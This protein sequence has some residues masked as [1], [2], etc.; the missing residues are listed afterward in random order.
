M[1]TVGKKKFDYTPSG[2]KKAA[3][4]A[5]KSGKPMVSKPATK[6]PKA[7]SRGMYK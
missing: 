4:F 1:P 2:K 7:K 5:A 6:K 3:A